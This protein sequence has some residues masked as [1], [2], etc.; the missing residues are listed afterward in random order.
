M[1]KIC[2]SFVLV[3]NIDNNNDTCNK[4][5]I[6]MTRIIDK[7][8]KYKVIFKN[9]INNKSQCFYKM[10]VTNHL[11]KCFIFN[12]QLRSKDTTQIAIV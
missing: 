2:E 9:K 8:E 5:K 11:I 4:C 12:Y 7:L 1:R 10:N 3:M 6:F